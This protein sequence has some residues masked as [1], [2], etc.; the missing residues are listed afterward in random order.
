MTRLLTCVQE[1]VSLDSLVG[2]E[3]ELGELLADPNAADPE[4]GSRVGYA[5]A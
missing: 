2:G 4:N 1:P 5:T 3:T